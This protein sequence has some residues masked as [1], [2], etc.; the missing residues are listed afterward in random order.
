MCRDA[1]SSFRDLGEG[2]VDGGDVGDDGLLV[3]RRNINI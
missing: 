2:I 3:W 1:L